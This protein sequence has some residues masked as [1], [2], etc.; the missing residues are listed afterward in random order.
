MP[1]NTSRFTVKGQPIHHFV[2]RFPF[3]VICFLIYSAD[4]NI[5][6]R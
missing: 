4:G 6:F 2:R 3:K 5:H 1:D